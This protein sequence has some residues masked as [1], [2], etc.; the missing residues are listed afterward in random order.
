VKVR[1]AASVLASILAACSSLPE[2]AARSLPVSDYAVSETSTAPEVPSTVPPPQAAALVY[3]IRGDGIIGRARL[4]TQ[5]PTA[6]DMIEALIE[7][8]TPTEAAR[9]LR[10]GLAVSVP[11]VVDVALDSGSATVSLSG[12]LESLPGDEQILIIGQIALTLAALEPSMTVRFIREGLP[13]SVVT[14]SGESVNRPVT[15]ADFAPL[16]SR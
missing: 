9:G 15:R 2:S 3:L 13:L 1:V 12:E 16:L 6:A 7:G 10:S 14:P 11:I 4:V 8:P 5:E